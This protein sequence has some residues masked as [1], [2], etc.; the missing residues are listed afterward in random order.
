MKIR[1]G[2]KEID[3]KRVWKISSVG[4]HIAL[5]TFHTGESIK[6]LC[7]RKPDGMTI[8]YPGTYEELKALIYKQNQGK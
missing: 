6:V 7:N 5:I 4:N 3:L 8:S 1:L 2:G